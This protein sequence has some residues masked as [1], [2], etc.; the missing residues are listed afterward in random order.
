MPHI[1]E[2]YDFTA[3]AYILHPTEPKI[4][5]H[6]HKKLNKWMHVGGHVELDEDPEQALTHEMEEETG[7]KRD[8]YEIIQVHDQPATDGHKQMPLPINVNVHPM[9]DSILP[10]HKHIDLVFLVKSKTDA[11]KPQEGE[12]QKIGWFTRKEIEDLKA[13]EKLFPGNY[14]TCVWILDHPKLKSVVADPKKK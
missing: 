4:C 10:N 9:K 8:Q 7:L 5:L 6:L 11:L 12:S 3:S 2:L 14:N 1:H 13:S